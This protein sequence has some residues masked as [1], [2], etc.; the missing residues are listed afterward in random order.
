MMFNIYMGLFLVNTFL[1][2]SREFARIM[3]DAKT[4]SLLHRQTQKVYKQK[5][6]IWIWSNHMHI[7]LFNKKLNVNWYFTNFNYR[8]IDKFVHPCARTSCTL[9]IARGNTACRTTYI[10]FTSGYI[11]FKF[12]GI[13]KRNTI[14]C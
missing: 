9:K 11:L 1:I 2:L 7:Y 13:R 8:S 6:D 4:K 5:I 10:P 3:V 12:R 14:K